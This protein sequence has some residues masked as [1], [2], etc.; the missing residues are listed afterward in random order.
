MRT[1]Y[2]L[3]CAGIALSAATL[4]AQKPKKEAPKKTTPEG[5]TDLGGGRVECRY[6][7]RM[8]EDSVRGR[9]FRRF[10]E[11]DS[12]AMRRAALGM[13]L[14]A[15]G[16][17][18]DTLGVFVTRVTPKGPAENAGIVEG[19]RIVSINGVDLRISSAD[20][21]DNY[22]NALPSHRLTRE[23]GKLTPGSRVNLRVYSGGRIRDVQVT[24][25]RASDVFKGERGF[26]FELGGPGMIYHGGPPADMRI[27]RE[28]PGPDMRIFREGPGADMRIFRDGMPMEFERMP[29]LDKR[30]LE[31]LRSSMPKMME[32]MD[33][34][35][36]LEPKLEEMR[37]KLRSLEGMK[38]RTL[39]PLQRIQP[40]RI[41][42]IDP[43]TIR[44][45]EN[46]PA[47]ASTETST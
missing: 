15:T 22:T 29:M 43:W 37:S 5:C 27:F 33:K 46:A 41:R 13:Q 44:I 20:V 36:M 24:A 10:A 45:M 16:S 17:V 2:L 30:Q 12:A 1:S 39:E 25:G 14:S 8:N 6:E 21:D 26:G 47:R 40:G 42:M 34:I 3:A 9:I 28:G 11:A 32:G 18:R 7:R 23:V 19:D 38:I 31:E 35:R 4:G